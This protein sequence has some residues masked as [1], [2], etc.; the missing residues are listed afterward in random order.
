MGMGWTRDRATGT[1]DVMATPERRWYEDETPVH[2]L[3]LVDT[4][5]E[6]QE[7]EWPLADEDPWAELAIIAVIC[8]L[9]LSVVVPLLP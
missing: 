8:F 9:L 3:H 7:P 6:P 4:K 5:R 2:R 1:G